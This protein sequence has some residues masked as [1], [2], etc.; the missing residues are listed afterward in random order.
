MK[1]ID[2]LLDQFEMLNLADEV[3]I[4]ADLRDRVAGLVTAE[5][6]PLAASKADSVAIPEWMEALYDLQDRLMIRYEDDVD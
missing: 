2:E 5:R 1:E 4:P 3:D 6:H